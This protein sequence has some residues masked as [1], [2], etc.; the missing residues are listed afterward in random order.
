MPSWPLLRLSFTSE[1]EAEGVEQGS[2]LGIGT[3]GGDDG[4]VHA[5]GGVDL[6]VVDL[7]EDE[8]LGDAERVVAPTVEAGRREAP[9]VADTRG[10]EADE[11]VEEL[12]HAIAA[13][14]DLRPD[15]VALAELETG[16]R[17]GRLG[18]E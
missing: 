8:L 3:G 5:P 12:P 6:V 9:E 11:A 15:A 4:D 17:L 10:G 1:R 2:S 18:D 14:R 13:Q 7:G 16:D